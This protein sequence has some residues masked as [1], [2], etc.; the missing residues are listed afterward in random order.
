MSYSLSNRAQLE[1][2]RPSRLEAEGA[3][4]RAEMKEQCSMRERKGN[5]VLNF[6]MDFVTEASAFT[7]AVGL[8]GGEQMQ[9]DPAYAR[10]FVEQSVI[11][12]LAHV[13]FIGFMM[14]NRGASALFTMMEWTHDPCAILKK[15]PMAGASSLVASPAQK[16]F[17]AIAGPLGMS[18]GLILSST[19]HQALADVNIQKCAAKVIGKLK[20]DKSIAEGKAACERAYEDWVLGAGTKVR[21]LVPDMLSMAVVVGIIG[22]INQTK[23]ALAPVGNAM[24][25][26]ATS[27]AQRVAGK[28]LNET[29][30]RFSYSLSQ[31]AIIYRGVTMGLTFGRWA[32]PPVV[33][34]AVAGVSAVAGGWLFLTL[35][36][37]VLPWIKN[38]WESFWQGRD[39][40]GTLTQLDTELTRL[41]GNGWVFTQLPRPLSCDM[42]LAGMGAPSYASNYKPA[43][44]FESAP[45]PA[46]LIEQM[47]D[48]QKKWRDHLMG[49]TMQAFSNWK[50]YV[51][52]FVNVYT[53]SQ[54]YYTRILRQINDYR[55][56]RND[57]DFEKPAI[58]DYEIMGGMAFEKGWDYYICHLPASSKAMFNDSI[59]SI[60]DE[61]VERRK[62]TLIL[63]KF[64]VGLFF[65]VSLV[66]KPKFDFG[67]M[68]TEFPGPETLA[69]LRDGLAAMNCDIKLPDDTSKMTAAQIEDLRWSKFERALTL[70]YWGVNGKADLSEEKN[71]TGVMG[72]ERIDLDSQ[73]YPEVAAYNI[74]MKVNYILGAP[75]PMALGGIGSIKKMNR[76]AYY[77][78]QEFKDQKPRDLR[79]V[80]TLNMTD[81]LLTSMVCGPA[82]RET[83]TRRK[84]AEGW[85]WDLSFA[86]P[87]VM[88]LD[89]DPCGETNNHIT[90]KVFSEVSRDKQHVLGAE[91]PR[92]DPYFTEWTVN[93]KVYRGMLELLKEFA[94]PT[95]VGTKE[96]PNAFAQ[97]WDANIETQ[98]APL[99]KQFR[100]EFV[101]EI[102]ERKYKPAIMNGE[103]TVEAK[104]VG[105]KGLAKGLRN[106][107]L[108]SLND[109]LK[110]LGQVG[111]ADSAAAQE[112]VQW[113][114]L[115]EKL[116]SQFR[117]SLVMI[118]PLQ[119]VQEAVRVYSKA[120]G[121]PEGGGNGTISSV[122]NKEAFA[123]FEASQTR[124]KQLINTV[125]GF[126]AARVNAQSPAAKKTL[127]PVAEALLKNITDL[128]TEIDSYHGVLVSP[129]LDTAG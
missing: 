10:H 60:D 32:G 112:Q 17:G 86:P 29:A 57:A 1:A 118:G 25:D 77:I 121:I 27:A 7:L 97:W 28:Y 54:K 94:S 111:V 64:H 72:D 89:F 90:K 76:D 107:I 30:L 83:I 34:F 12:P 84:I 93:G 126:V 105:K 120:Y 46:K 91:V 62:P 14:G 71:I 49:D 102:L 113:I 2:L 59:K 98:A 117:M 24:K 20:T 73:L 33:R 35:Q 100:S 88:N 61:I 5:A 8:S 104:I 99:F 47:A 69:I 9:E 106:S 92:V 124:N 43:I 45:V 55:F 109:N 67:R 66:N 101:N 80:D 40:N 53:G 58:Y 87:R 44:C 65:N 41:E 128:V 68:M 79:N 37:T 75:T 82:S 63:P 85:G 18:A 38:P 127:I 39:I 129:R 48:Q 95:M 23:L 96:N 125:R 15:N 70:L 108:D 31:R 11:D 3:R 19:M 36:D 115:A 26:R 4:M 16:R 52:K 50:D 81:Y 74:F 110:Y 119:G 116:R 114:Q 78:N 13:S 21:D 22:K 103:Y 123:Y 51:L 56:K 122:L 6:G 42:N